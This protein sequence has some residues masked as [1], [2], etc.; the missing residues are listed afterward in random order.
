MGPQ[1]SPPARFSVGMKQTLIIRTVRGML[2]QLRFSL[3]VKC[4]GKT[5][6]SVFPW[7]RRRPRLHVFVFPHGGS[8]FPAPPISTTKT[9]PLCLELLDWLVTQ[10][11]R[12]PATPNSFSFSPICLP[13]CLC[14]CGGC[15]RGRLRSQERPLCGKW[16]AL[17]VG[18]EP[19]LLVMCSTL[20]GGFGVV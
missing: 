15:R 14:Q 19:R 3:H 17:D 6:R 5:P 18:A 11:H 12:D 2:S 16:F 13:V 8:G 9:K 7:D 4:L 1:A 20:F 10:E